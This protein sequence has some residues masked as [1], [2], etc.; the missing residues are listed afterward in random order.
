MADVLHRLPDLNS[1]T[2]SEFA[3]KSF[4]NGQQDRLSSITDLRIFDT[5]LFEIMAKKCV[6]LERLWI[7]ANSPS[8][9]LSIDP[10]LFNFTKLTRLTLLHV[11]MSDICFELF[12]SFSHLNVLK[13]R[14][15]HV[16]SKDSLNIFCT[17]LSQI[18]ISRLDLEVDFTSKRF[19]QRLIEETSVRWLRTSFLFLPRRDS[20]S[21]LSFIKRLSKKVTPPSFC[22][23]ERADFVYYLAQER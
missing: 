11:A 13:M 18:P 22:L 1:I 19:I 16:E 23:R 15:V 9:T 20:D 10:Y 21:I 5:E 12:S 8:L 6:N 2:V 7:G 4:E 3:I 17:S 14:D